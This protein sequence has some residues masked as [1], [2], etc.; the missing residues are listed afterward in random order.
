MNL[1]LFRSSWLLK[2]LEFVQTMIFSLGLGIIPFIWWPWASQQFELPR[3][4]FVLGWIELL[5]IITVLKVGMSSQFHFN[6]MIGKVILVYFLA[7]LLSLATSVDRGKSLVGNYYR[8]DGLIT[9]IHLFLLSFITASVWNREKMSY[10]CRVIAIGS[11]L[12]S[13]LALL[14]LPIHIFISK[15]AG[16]VMLST[17]GQPNYLAGYLIITLP[18]V[19]YLFQKSRVRSEKIYYSAGFV[20][21]ILTIILTKSWGG[22]LGL[23]LFLAITVSLSSTIPLYLKKIVIGSGILGMF[24]IV[25]VYIYFISQ[26]PPA[27]LAESRERIFVKAILSYTKKPITGWGI[28]NFDHAFESVEWP[29]HYSADIYVDKAHST[30]LENLVTGGIVGLGAFI[31]FLYT[32]SRRMVQHFFTP[33]R[34][35]F[36]PLLL[37]LVLYIFHSQT[38][39][40]SIAEEI[41]F[42]IVIGVAGVKS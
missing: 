18:F 31:F 24:L 33:D 20:I 9:Y 6:R 21:Q 5:C 10:F 14:S 28:A 16:E 29:I 15:T 40:I 12:T 3:I 30:L 13:S 39:V 26:T 32:V 19:F 4:W 25:S 1:P 11:I 23:I 27:V 2:T 37:V 17:F 42:W 34:G 36:L 8:I 38:N 22:I 41:F 35:I 7:L